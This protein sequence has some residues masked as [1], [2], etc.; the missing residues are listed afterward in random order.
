M[1]YLRKKIWVKIG[2]FCPKL[3]S[4]WEIS[5]GISPR[6][7]VR[8][9]R[10]SVYGYRRY[11]F[12]MQYS[13]LQF[14]VGSGSWASS[15]VVMEVPSGTR[16]RIWRARGDHLVSRLLHGIAIDA[17]KATSGP[18]SAISACCWHRHGAKKEPLCILKS[19]LKNTLYRVFQYEVVSFDAK[20]WSL[21][22][23][24][25]GTKS[26]LR[27]RNLFTFQKE[28]IVALFEK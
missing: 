3:K 26:T 6:S 21:N 25:K 7:T 27:F 20:L 16:R 24:I 4:K 5:L 15:H 23:N 22:I 12:L 14:T 17:D 19:I 18:Y 2:E 10:L 11:I 9:A 13:Y 28:K 1:L 8:N